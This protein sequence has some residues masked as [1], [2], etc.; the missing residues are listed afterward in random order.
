MCVCFVFVCVTINTTK[1][2]N[3]IVVK[4]SEDDYDETFREAFE[5]WS[6]PS[7]M[8][9]RDLEDRWSLNSLDYNA[10]CLGINAIAITKRFLRH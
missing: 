3:K 2:V 4:V 6:L 9:E 8:T 5:G 1:K 10:C 7:D